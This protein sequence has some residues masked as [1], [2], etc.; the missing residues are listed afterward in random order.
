M[1]Y[2][3]DVGLAHRGVMRNEKTYFDASSANGLFQVEHGDLLGSLARKFD[4]GDRFTGSFDRY[5]NH[6]DYAD[7]TD[8]LVSV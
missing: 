1:N 8:Q 7:G 5:A 6:V 2:V 4:L 3:S